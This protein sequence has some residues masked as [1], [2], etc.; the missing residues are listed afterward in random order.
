M[1]NI[2]IGQFAVG[3]AFIV[4]LWKGF[5]FL[6]EKVNKPLITLQEQIA[7]LHE[8]SDMTLQMCQKMI[9]HELTGDHVVD[10]QALY[11]K[12]DDYRTKRANKKK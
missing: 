10:M 2:T 12:V 4:T 8:Q 5:D 3:I 11:D 1:E 7:D 6:T 9:L